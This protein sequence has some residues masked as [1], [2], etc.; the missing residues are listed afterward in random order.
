MRRPLLI[1]IGGLLLVEALAAQ[2]P[3]HAVWEYA[4][5]EIGDVTTF[6][7]R[8]DGA[9]AYEAIGIPTADVLDTT[10]PGH[11][12]YRWAIPALGHGPHTIAVRACN[13]VECSLDATAVFR[14]IGPP[15]HLRV[16]R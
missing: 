15:Q 13:A 10:P 2:P 3:R 9:T 14:L 4:D 7:V 5:A 12:S 1:A 11:K 6:E 16:V 8:L